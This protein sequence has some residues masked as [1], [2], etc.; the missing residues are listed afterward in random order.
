MT[1]D[2]YRKMRPP[3]SRWRRDARRTII[4]VVEVL[5]LAAPTVLAD[6]KELLARVDAAYPFGQRKHEPYKCWLTERRLFI[7]AIRDK[8]TLPTEDE[9]GV[10]EVARDLVELG[11]EDEARTL[12]EEQAPHRLARKCPA[13]DAKSGRPCRDFLYE[14]PPVMGYG[15]YPTGEVHLIVP[16]YARLVGHLGNGPLFGGQS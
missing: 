2:D 3:D 15:Q 4:E 5:E 12:V 16:H 10:C 6:P 11:R 14:D 13:C 1:L 9:I 7:E 8:T